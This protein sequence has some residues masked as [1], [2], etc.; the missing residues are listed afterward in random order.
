MIGWL[1]SKGKSKPAFDDLKTAV[2]H[3]SVTASFTC[4][5]FSTRRL[6]D[7]DAADVAGRLAELRGYT[8]FA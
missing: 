7:V 5:A 6:Q 3:G 4:E 1:A 2:A 8:A